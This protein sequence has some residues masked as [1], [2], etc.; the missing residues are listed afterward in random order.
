MSQKYEYAGFWIRLAASILDSILLMLILL[1]IGLLVAPDTYDWT[2]TSYSWFD[3]FYQIFW[4]VFVIMCWIK[5][6]GTPAKRLLKLKVL[7]AQTGQ[8]LGLG[9]SVIRYIGYIPSTLVLF[10]GFFWIGWDAKK[11]G[12]HDKM[13]KSVVVKEID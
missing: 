3:V 9:Q 13:A 2:N 6:A 10:L 4:A 8:H 7:D 11:Q 1:P 12:W 5:F